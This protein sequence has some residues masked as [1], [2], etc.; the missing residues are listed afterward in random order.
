[1]ADIQ[2]PEW[3]HFLE[4]LFF[5][6]VDFMR[7]VCDIGVFQPFP[8]SIDKLSVNG[9]VQTAVVLRLIH[10]K[11]DGIQTEIRTLAVIRSDGF[12]EGTGV[13]VWLAGV[14]GARDVIRLPART[15]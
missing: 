13:S 7:Y 11:P 10:E 3:M 2:A 1:M 9:L 5:A 15:R 4:K 8:E 12:S 6:M 14:T